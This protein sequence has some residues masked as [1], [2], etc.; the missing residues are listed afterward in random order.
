MNDNKEDLI[1]IVRIEPTYK[2]HGIRA[3][4]FE[5]IA[6]VRRDEHMNIWQAFIF[7]DNIE[8]YP[9]RLPLSF[10]KTIARIGSLI[11]QLLGYQ[12]EYEEYTTRIFES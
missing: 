1:I 11:G 3:E 6:G 8:T 12:T 7:L 9:T 10:L 5:N 2:T 4:S